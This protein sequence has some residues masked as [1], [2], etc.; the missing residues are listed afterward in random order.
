ML[1]TLI[2]S[3]VV[4]FCFDDSKK[5][6]KIYLKC[7]KK[8]VQCNIFFC[9]CKHIEMIRTLFAGQNIQLTIIPSRWSS[10]W[11][12]DTQWSD[13]LVRQ[14]GTGLG[15]Y[16]NDIS[17]I[18]NFIDLKITYLDH[19]SIKYQIEERLRHQLKRINTW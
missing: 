14:P 15:R 8:H 4:R 16:H 6:M 5:T 9:H 18:I 7:K 11:S 1:W 3:S 10:F 12:G 13:R 2:Y 19:I 17:N